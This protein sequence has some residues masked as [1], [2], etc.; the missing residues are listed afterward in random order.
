M[1]APHL[2]HPLDPVQERARVAQLGLDVDRLVAVDRVHQ[3]RQVE[4]GEVGAGEP[5]VA[6]G[7][8]LHG[9]THGVAVT[10]V[11]VV[12]HAD[13]VA[14]VHDRAAGQAEE[15]GVEQLDHPPVV[16]EQRD[17]PP[18]DAHVALH[19]RILGVLGVHVV[20]LVVG[21][22]LEGQLVVVAQEDPP[23]AAVGDRPGSGP[24]ISV[25]GKRCSRRTAMYMRGIS[26]KWKL[27]WHS[28]PSPK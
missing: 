9:R 15:Q 7:R 13:L 26:G 8:P 21:D 10:Q 14:V 11:D 23:L 18:G 5:A 27:M 3:R 6:V 17:E 24:R 28:S 22:H 2:E 20:A 25:I 4:L 12:A 19:A 1:L 16:V